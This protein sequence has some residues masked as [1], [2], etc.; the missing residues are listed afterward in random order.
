MLY[1]WHET[2]RE[3]LDERRI[4][5][6]AN[7]TANNILKDWTENRRPALSEMLIEER[8]PVRHFGLTHVSCATAT[9]LS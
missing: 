8:L 1:E 7:H 2:E 6:R 9:I 3:D 4:W 5:I